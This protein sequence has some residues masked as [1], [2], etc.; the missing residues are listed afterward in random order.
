MSGIEIAALVIFVIGYVFIT[1]EHQIKTQKAPLSLVMAGVLWFLVSRHDV[2]FQHHMEEAGWEITQ[3]VFFLLFAMTLVELISRLGF[4]EL[5]RARLMERRWNN[6]R[7]FLVIMLLTFFFSAVLDN[8]TTAIVMSEISRRF[9]R[10]RNLLVAAAGVVIVS[11]AGG[12]W[13]PIGD[14]TTIMLWLAGKFS[15]AEVFTHTFLPS[16]VHA[17]IATSMLVRL[18]D[19]DS[20]DDSSENGQL[21]FSTA[22]KVLMTV[23]LL[24]FALP[25][26]AT[27]LD[28]APFI[29]LGFGFGVVG[30]LTEFFVQSAGDPD[31]EADGETS[32]RRSPQLTRM[33]HD[34]QEV[35]KEVDFSSLIFFVGILLSVAALGAL[36]VLDSLSD[37]LFG[38]DPSDARIVT[39]SVLMGWSSAVVD[40]VPLTAVAIDTVPTSDS[41][42]W[43]LLAYAVGTGGSHLVI[44]SAAGVVVMGRVRGLTSTAFARIALVPV[45]IAYVAGIGVWLLQRAIFG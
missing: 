11:N 10:D 14:V 28:L 32:N 2:D 29:G 26:V 37:S 30:V 16:A 13:S 43:A 35:I 27:Q 44:G 18:L 45:F 7:Q 3:I 12:A 22:A 33:Q 19:D 9:F 4:F 5:I 21:S 23:S 39:R 1:F 40:N 15:A 8:L 24:C 17:V 34:I 42:L 38:D 6:R 25:F 36:G 41:G 20:V 31:E